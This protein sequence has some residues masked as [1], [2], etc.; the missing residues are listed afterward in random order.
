MKKRIFTIILVIAM[1][2]AMTACVGNTAQI[3]AAE[4]VAETIASIKEATDTARVR[5]YNELNTMS[6]EEISDYMAELVRISET[7]NLSSQDMYELGGYFS[8]IWQANVSVCNMNEYKVQAYMAFENCYEQAIEQQILLDELY[9]WTWVPVADVLCKYFSSDNFSEERAKDLFCPAFYALSKEE[10]LLV[11]EAVFDNPVFANNTWI[12]GLE[13][14]HS[15]YTEVQ[16]MGWE[17][18]RALSKSS[19]SKVT[20]RTSSIC[21]NLFSAPEVLCYV[22]ERNQDEVFE[23]ARNI[24]DNTCYDFVDK[25]T[26]FCGSYEYN[27]NINNLAIENLLN[28]AKDCNQETAEKIKAVA[29]GLLNGYHDTETANMLL[30]ALEENF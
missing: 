6:N 10:A 12:A 25:Y 22:D 11:A 20:E 21:Y 8:N 1:V 3:T 17:H 2:M 28:M 26:Y 14:V 19:D 15:P 18:L 7:E 16:E 30:N 5:S 4:S 13:V 27:T 23:I 9:S 29:D 24:M